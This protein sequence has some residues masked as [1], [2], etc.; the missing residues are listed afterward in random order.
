[1]KYTIKNLRQKGYKVRVI[2]S[3]EYYI[4]PT[5]SGY[6]KELLAQGGST[7]IE[8]TT[9]DKQVNVFGKAVCSL[10]DNFNRRVGNEIALGRAIE[11]LKNK[12]SEI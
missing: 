7:T 5:I 12:V 6:S 11:E 8:I 10:S 3:R 2:H 1:M 9:P 4:K